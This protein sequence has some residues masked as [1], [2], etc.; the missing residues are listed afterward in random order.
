MLRLLGLIS[1]FLAITKAY[2]FPCYVTVAKENCWVDYDVNVTVIDAKTRQPL[3]A[4]H[5]AKGDMWG[6]ASFTCQPGE[7]LMYSAT[8]APTI[9]DGE[10]NN[11]YEA[12]RFWSLPT[13][14]RPK[15]LAWEINV[16]FAQ[17]FS[18][19]P[20]PPQASGVCVCD[21][22]SIPPIQAQ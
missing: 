11:V 19:V 10:E 3:S 21:F 8:F 16:C 18:G 20:L 9:W 6:R 1:I 14:P 22:K 12:L 15:E 13:A 2:A 17:A 7:T 5:I 4:V